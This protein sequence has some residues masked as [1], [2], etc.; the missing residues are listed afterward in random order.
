MQAI[1]TKAALT[2]LMLAV[3]GAAAGPAV[4]EGASRGDAPTQRSTTQAPRVASAYPGITGPTEKFVVSL[5]DYTMRLFVS[6]VADKN[7]ERLWQHASPKFQQA[8]SVE[9]MNDAFKGFFGMITGDPLAAKS[10]IFTRPPVV[11]EQGNLVVNGFYATA[12]SRLVFRLTYGL[13]GRSWKLLN[14][15]ASTQP[16]NQPDQGHRQPSSADRG[17][18]VGNG[19]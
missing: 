18:S 15:N 19:A 8:V 10:P 12:P 11:D 3:A 1:R 16:L 17:K 5:S 9:K 4:A 13:E 14:I 2:L 6:S 7:M